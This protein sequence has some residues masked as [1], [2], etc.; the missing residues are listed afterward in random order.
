[1]TEPP[2]PPPRPRH[3]GTGRRPGGP[4]GEVRSRH[5]GVYLAPSELAALKALAARLGRPQ[6]EVARTA[7]LAALR[8]SG[9]LPGA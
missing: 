9:E 3:P 4:N 6:A 1:M 8:A 2:P 7:L 5:L